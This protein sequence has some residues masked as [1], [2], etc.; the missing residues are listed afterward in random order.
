M[1]IQRLVE[2]LQRR[3]VFRVVGAYLV[4]SWF[5]LEVT[6][7]VSGLLDWTHPVAKYV[8]FAAIAGIP[9]MLVLSWMFDLTKD[10]IIRTPSLEEVQRQSAA[11][12]SPDVTHLS[13]PAVRQDRPP[14]VV[15]SARATGMFGLGILVAIV[16]LA[17]YTRVMQPV[18]VDDQLAADGA[19]LANIRAIAVLPF[20]D[21]SELH[22]QQYFADGMTEELMNRLAQVAQ[23]QIV[24]GEGYAGTSRGGDLRSIAERLKVQAILQGSVRKSQGSMRITVKLINPATNALLYSE[25]FTRPTSNVFQ[26]QDEIASAV[27]SS[28]ELQITNG[29]AQASASRGTTNAE[30]Y[31]LYSKGQAALN[32]RTEPALRL[33]LDLFE[34]AIALDPRFALAHAGIAQV[35]AVLP[36]VSAFPFEEAGNK[37]TAAAAVAIGLAPTLGQAHAALGQIT[38]NIGWNPAMAETSYENAITFMPSYGTA[39]QWYAETLTMLGRTGEAVVEI[40]E[41]MRLMPNSPAARNTLGYLL[42]IR[43][44][45]DSALVVFRNGAAAYPEYRLGHLTHALTALTAKKYS[46]AEAAARA[47]AGDDAK[48][49]AALTNVIRGAAGTVPRAE[50]SRAA[51]SLES[52][53]GSG[54]TALWFAGIG[55][56]DSALRL[57][58]KTHAARNDANFPYFVIHPLLKPLHG[59][60]AYQAIVQNLGVVPA[61]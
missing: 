9:V 41:A 46:E 27:A 43:G 11:Q 8:L 5:A 24:S 61:R 6:D 2:E 25:S 16:S 50:A 7:T 18:T 42:T 33:A 31:D 29:M 55:D 40:E 14:Q 12:G 32:T 1:T 57:V 48:L 60:A 38:Q 37:G 51:A 19:T 17:A 58:R 10:G 39:H 49:A 45:L 20:E 28:L 47:Y 44:E 52:A 53:L 34:R 54:F 4:A 13:M 26:V 56:H 15:L 59:S 35:Y 22:D 36:T 30:A 23:L 21:I 3:R